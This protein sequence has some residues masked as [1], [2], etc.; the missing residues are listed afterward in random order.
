[1]NDDPRLTRL[2]EN[3]THLQHHVTE[4]DKVIL[5]LTEDVARLKQELATQRAQAESTG[6]GES[7]LAAMKSWLDANE[8][9]AL[10]LMALNYRYARYVYEKPDVIAPI[11]MR[12]MNEHSGG[13]L[14]VEDIK[15]I[16]PQF[17][18]PRPY[19]EEIEKTFNPDSDL[20]W[21]KSAEYYVTTSTDL[22]ADADW[23]RNNPLDEWFNKFLQRKDLLEW[24]DR[25]LD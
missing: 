10:K 21:G 13:N 1:M 20:Y 3:L 24:V 25:P 2:E 19:Q 23:R 14:T 6:T 15:F 16:I 11:V 5:G 9:T 18:D 4:Q 7:P 17:S 12:N 8:E 22:P